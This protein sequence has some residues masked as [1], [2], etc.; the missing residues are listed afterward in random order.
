MQASFYYGD[1]EREYNASYYRVML[2]GQVLQAAGHEIVYGSAMFHSHQDGSHRVDHIDYS[3][4]CETVLLERMVTRDRL[5]MLRLAG[6]KRIVLTFDDNYSAMPP[7]THAHEYWVKRGMHTELLRCLPMVDQVVVASDYLARVYQPYCR[8][9]IRVINNYLDWNKWQPAWTKR[10]ER[11]QAGGPLT[12]GWGGTKLHRN[13]WNPSYLPTLLRQ[14]QEQFGDRVRFLFYNN[15]ADLVLNAA[16]LEFESRP[17][18]ALDDWPM[19]VA[20][21]DLGLIPLQGEYDAGRSHLKALEYATLG[22]PWVGDWL[23]PVNE[24]GGGIAVRG[25]WAGGSARDE[26]QVWHDSLVR[27]IEERERYNAYA[28]HGIEWARH[29]RAEFCQVPYEEVLWPTK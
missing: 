29:W 3:T 8:T 27:L 10:R 22:I 12:I 9:K 6:A 15:V 26:R 17:L 16:G 7:Q 23:P 25:S 19:C 11:Q 18:Q 24:A 1:D 28:E 14:L 20:D 2:P 13:S 21:L 4:V 5:R